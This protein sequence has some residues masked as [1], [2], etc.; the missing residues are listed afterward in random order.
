[1]LLAELSESEELP[2]PLE[3]DE[4]DEEEEDDVVLEPEVLPLNLGFGG[5]LRESKIN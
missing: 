1:M 4:D 3:D 5:I 2:L